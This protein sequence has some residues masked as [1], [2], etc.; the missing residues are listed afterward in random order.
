MMFILEVAATLLDR[1][2]VYSRRH[3]KIDQVSG[4]EVKDGNPPPDLLT[5][6]GLESNPPNS[7][8]Q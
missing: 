1:R 2:I 8:L 4:D 3:L 6:S 7:R 5:V